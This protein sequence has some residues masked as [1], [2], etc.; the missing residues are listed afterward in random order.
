MNNKIIWI[1]RKTPK[2]V[3]LPFVFKSELK[4][5]TYD[6]H[7]LW[8]LKTNLNSISYSENEGDHK[9][10]ENILLIAW[11]PHELQKN[12]KIVNFYVKA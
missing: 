3:S 7:H 8:I 6:K 11:K 10:N 2:N 12:V 5:D 1:L 4:L 9:Q